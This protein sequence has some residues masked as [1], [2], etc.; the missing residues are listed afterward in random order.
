MTSELGATRRARD[1]H[2]YTK[3]PCQGRLLL[4]RI[5]PWNPPRSL[6]R[7]RCCSSKTSLISSRLVLSRLCSSAFSLSLSFSLEVDRTDE[8]MT[9]GEFT[10]VNLY[11]DS[12]VHSPRLRSLHMHNSRLHE[13]A[14]RP[15]ATVSF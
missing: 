14:P 11:L 6:L 4:T 10:V 3:D 8:R 9:S 2:G 12:L 15:C 13:T 5:I 7:A 1:I